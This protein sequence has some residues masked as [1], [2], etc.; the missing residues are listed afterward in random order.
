MIASFGNL[1]VGG[2]ARRGKQARSVLVVKIAGKLGGGPVP[3]VAR[4]ASGSLAGIAL[5]A[6]GEWVG[7]AAGRWC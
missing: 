7:Y 3:R 1:D 4:E 6:G 5:G 2:V